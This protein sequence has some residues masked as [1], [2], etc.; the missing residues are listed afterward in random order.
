[1]L[2]EYH[3]L[4]VRLP[5]YMDLANI[6][7]ELDLTTSQLASWGGLVDTFEDVRDAVEALDT[8]AGCQ[9]GEHAPGLE[10]VLEMQAR[11]LA[12]RL[13]AV[14]RLHGAVAKLGRVLSPRQRARADRL[15]AIHFRE[16]G[17]APHRLS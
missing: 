15:L 7:A 9:L 12:V 10:D 14:R 3:N 4:P 13:G 17:G 5:A 16:L 2:H 8:I 11:S 6:E 1:M